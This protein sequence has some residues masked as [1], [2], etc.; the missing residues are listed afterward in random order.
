MTYFGIEM[1]SAK[2]LMAEL[3]LKDN[4][5][6]SWLIKKGLKP[7]RIGRLNYFCKEQIQNWLRTGEF[8]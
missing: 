3:G 2:E 6:V 5:R 7:T 8:K 1:V 4:S